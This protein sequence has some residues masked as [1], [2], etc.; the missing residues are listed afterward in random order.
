MDNEPSAI[1]RACANPG[2]GNAFRLAKALGVSA[3]TV[4]QWVRGQRPI[5]ARWC[6]PIEAA[7]GG[8]V[9]RHDL[10]PDVFGAPPPASAAPNAADQQAA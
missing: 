7:T 2:V 8:E 9:T 3:P 5:P 1:E 4:Y 10:R 6:I